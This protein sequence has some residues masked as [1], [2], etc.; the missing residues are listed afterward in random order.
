MSFGDVG[1]FVERSVGGVGV[2]IE[3]RDLHQVVS[4]C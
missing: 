3:E 2:G 4:V 1:F